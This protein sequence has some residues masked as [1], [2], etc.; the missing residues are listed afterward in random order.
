MFKKRLAILL[1]I[2]TLLSFIIFPTQNPSA[3][4]LSVYINDQPQH[5]TPAPIIQSGTTLVPM[6]A[7]FEALGANVGWDNSTRTA[8]GKRGD[9]TVTLT[10][11]SQTAYVNGQPKTLE[12]PAQLVNSLAYIPLRFVSESLG[13][14]VEYIHETRTIKITSLDM[15]KTTQVLDKSREQYLSED[16]Y[17]N[18]DGDFIIKLP[19]G[20]KIKDIA[21]RISFQ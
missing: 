19:H 1:T 21:M 4:E 15:I 20:W 2:I 11:G 17:K 5:F 18:I 8:T 9:I 6:R 7:F 3:S 13:D 14:K 12:V 16:Y 10:I